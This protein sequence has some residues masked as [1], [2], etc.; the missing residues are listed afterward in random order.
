MVIP[1]GKHKGMTVAEMLA[2]DPAYADWVANQGWVAE[3][4]AEL[5]AAILARGA[6]SD[7]SPEHNTIQARFLEPEFRTACLLAADPESLKVTRD[8]FKKRLILLTKYQISDARDLLKRKEEEGIISRA[9]RILKT[10]P[11]ELDELKSDS[12]PF[13]LT[14]AVKFEVR[15]VDAV[16]HWQFSVERKMDWQECIRSG[17]INPDLSK[18][19]EGN[20]DRGALNVEIKPSMG[21]DFP[22]VM[23]QMERLRARALVLEEYTGRAVPAPQIRQMFAASG[24]SLV[25]L[26]DIEAEIP[27]VRAA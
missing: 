7:D 10:A 11:V 14:T 27:N 22:T 1:F 20:Y 5:H 13:T 18:H 26:R 4:F 15:G 12:I 9:T 16:I 24:Y 2:I 3:R 19:G 8:E 23:R 6:V 25:F 17:A 21:D